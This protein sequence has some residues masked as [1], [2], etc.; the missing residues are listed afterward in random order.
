MKAMV[1]FLASSSYVAGQGFSRFQSWSP[2]PVISDGG[3]FVVNRHT[4][5]K[6]VTLS[7][8][9][10]STTYPTKRAWNM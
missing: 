1:S 6:I 5:C 2:A 9:C 4:W 3:T 8:A 7:Y 10:E